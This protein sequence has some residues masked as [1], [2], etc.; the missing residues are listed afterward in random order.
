MAFSLIILAKRS[1]FDFAHKNILKTNLIPL[2][3]GFFAKSLVKGDE[4]KHT[5]QINLLI[6][7][8]TTIMKQMKNDQEKVSQD[9]FTLLGEILHR[10]SKKSVQE[11]CIQGILRIN[12]FSGNLKDIYQMIQQWNPA[13]QISEHTQLMVQT[14]VHRKER[15]FFKV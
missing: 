13:Y 7:S 4:D 6:E 3:K 8:I 14:F 12:R 5:D 1:Y 9:V 10:T 15:T 11:S 2:L